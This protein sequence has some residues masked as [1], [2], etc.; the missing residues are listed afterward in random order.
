MADT[1]ASPALGLFLEKWHR[2]LR[3]EL[4]GCLDELLVDDVV[5]KSPIVFTPSRASTPTASI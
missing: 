1:S 5:F 4:P 3:G 2:Q